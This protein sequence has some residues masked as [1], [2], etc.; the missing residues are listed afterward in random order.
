MEAQNDS[1]ALR[2]TPEE[3]EGIMQA[4]RDY[5]EGWYNAEPERMARCLH[6]ALIKR[7]IVSDPQAEGLQVG[8]TRSATDMVGYTQDGGGS[9][10]PPAERGHEITILDVFRDIATVKV[11][12]HDYMDYLH[13]AKFEDGWKLLNVLWEVREG[14]VEGE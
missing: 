6:P 10:V 12:S 7:T 8:P 14:I 9:D 2:A 13:L 5:I 11:L 1:R 3:I 4:S